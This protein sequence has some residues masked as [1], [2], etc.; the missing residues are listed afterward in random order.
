MQASPQ[1][2]CAKARALIS[3][4]DPAA[5][6]PGILAWLDGSK[7]NGRRFTDFLDF[8]DNEGLTNLFSSWQSSEGNDLK[9]AAVSQYGSF[10]IFSLLDSVGHPTRHPMVRAANWIYHN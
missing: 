1:M 2:W 3:Q 10:R 8:F 9:L 4:Q 7:E 6:E 5:Y